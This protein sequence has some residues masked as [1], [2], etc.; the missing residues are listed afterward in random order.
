ML[1]SL[2][3]TDT[4]LKQFYFL[5]YKKLVFKFYIQCTIHYGE[6]RY[7]NNHLINLI[8]DLQINS[9]FTHFPLTI[10][11]FYKQQQ[12]DKQIIL[13]QKLQNFL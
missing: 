9:V 8:F 1:Y 12:T 11:I 3:F 2:R 4:G 7:V 10:F 13:K 6:M 5:F